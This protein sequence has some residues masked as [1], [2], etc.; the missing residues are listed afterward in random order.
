MLIALAATII[1]AALWLVA[2]RPKTAEIADTP[3]APV[4]AIAKAKDA[5]AAS[6][7]ANA[8][9]AAAT[10]GTA[11]AAAPATAAAPAATPSAKTAAPVAEPANKRDAAVV[12]DIRRGKVVVLLFWN[13]KGSDDVA[14]RG[15]VRGLSR[16]GGKVAV[17]VIP[18]SRVG[19]YE[20]ITQGVT[21][22]QSPTTLVI[23]RKRRSR[24]I[25][26]LSE[27]GE[28][29]QAVNDALAGRR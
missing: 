27:R 2:L 26:G 6:D 5:S 19:Q 23:D 29:S 4:T 11:N 22:N 18:I 9:L 8:K 1:L 24:A 7:A 13:A 16:H 28:L 17:H 10:G 15:A 20:S 12:R 21:V 14:T 25:V 3:A